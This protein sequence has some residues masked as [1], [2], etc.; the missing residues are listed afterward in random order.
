MLPSATKKTREP[1]IVISTSPGGNLTK[2]VLDLI[3][4]FLESIKTSIN[5]IAYGEQTSLGHE[6]E[7]I[8]DTTSQLWVRRDAMNEQIPFPS[9]KDWAAS[10][11]TVEHPHCRSPHVNPL[12]QPSPF[13]GVFGRREAPSG[14][15]LPASA[16]DMSDLSHPVYAPSGAVLKDE[17]DLGKPLNTDPK[18]PVM[19]RKSPFNV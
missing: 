8:Y 13:R 5:R 17:V 19:I 16:V 4:A 14:V 3:K 18:I 11:S 12:V 2:D 15:T 9:N 10:P 6:N 7:Y 1:Q